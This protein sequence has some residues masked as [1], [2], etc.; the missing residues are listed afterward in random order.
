MLGGWWREDVDYRWVVGALAARATLGVLRAAIGLCGLAGPTIGLLTV[1]SAQSPQHQPA[2]IALW[3]LI[4]LG[5]VWTLR[6]WLGGWPSEWESLLLA[7]SA[8]I[9]ITLVCA[10]SPGYVVRSVGMMLLLIVGV[11]VSA[12]HGTKALAVHTIWSLTAAVLLAVPMFSSGDIS[13]AVIL[14]LGMGA[15]VV[16]PPGL[17]FCYWALRSEMLSDPLTMLLSRRGL[18]YH[19]AVLFARPGPIPVS[20][21]M[22]DLDRFKTVNDTFG[23]SA[24][25][26]VLVRT[27]E[28]LRRAAPAHSIVSRFGGEEFA[29]IV[30]MPVEDAHAAA[31]RL[32]RAVAEPIGS[33]SVTASIGL[34]VFHAPAARPCDQPV[35]EVIRSADTAMYQ[36]KQRGGN[37]VVVAGRLS[38]LSPASEGRSNHVRHRA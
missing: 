11:Y 13:S 21:M 17:Q 7:A 29:I 1:L 12:F 24:G 15:A 14:I 34:A 37:A 38:M 28:R 4:A 27:A 36:A 23:H 2:R 18:D 25:D 35:R 26:D 19:S 22:I 33:I 8:D 30:R 32:L 5:V 3:V 31:E 6:W 10:L 16:V 9:C 20:V